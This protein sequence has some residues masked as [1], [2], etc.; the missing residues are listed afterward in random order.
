M[1]GRWP[2]PLKKTDKNA[3]SGRLSEKALLQMVDDLERELAPA[4]A[5]VGKTGSQAPN[6]PVMIPAPLH[7]RR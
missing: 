7:R 4:S 1:K 5:L 6:E 2:M 3:E